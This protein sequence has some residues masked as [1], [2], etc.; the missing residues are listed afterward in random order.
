MHRSLAEKLLGSE[1]PMRADPVYFYEYNEFSNAIFIPV[2][3]PYYSREQ[4]TL[5]FHEI[6]RP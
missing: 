3:I 2:G 4:L 1:K 5:S 6:E